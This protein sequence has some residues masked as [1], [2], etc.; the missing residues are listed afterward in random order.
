MN[1]IKF[2][3]K[4]PQYSDLSDKQLADALHEKFYKD[5]PIKQFY[6]DVGLS[7][8]QASAKNSNLKPNQN[9]D[10]T[11]ISTELA[12]NSITQ[13]IEP[14]QSDIL[15]YSLL[16]VVGFLFWLSKTSSN[17]KSDLKKQ[18]ILEAEYSRAKEF[19]KQTRLEAEGIKVDAVKLKTLQTELNHARSEIE[20]QARAEAER[21]KTTTAKQKTLEIE[22]NQIRTELEKRAR[23]EAERIKS[24]TARQVA[25]EAELNKSKTFEKHAKSEAELIKIE[26][27][28]LATLELDIKQA[29]E[30]LERRVRLEAERTKADALRQNA[31]EAE[32]NKSRSLEKQARMEA[33]RIKA[34]HDKSKSIQDG[35]ENDLNK[36][37][38]E[39]LFDVGEVVKVIGGAF[40]NFNGVVEEVNYE[41]NKLKISVLIIGR[42][43]SV[44]LSFEQVLKNHY[45]LGEVGPYGGIVFYV[46]DTGTIGAEVKRK[47]EAGRLNWHKSL[48]ATSES[49]KDWRLPTK[50][51]L[52]IL[53]V[54]K[55]L[56]GGFTNT[57]YWCSTEYN[58][59]DAWIQCF[60]TGYPYF[61]NKNVKKNNVRA[62]RSFDFSIIEAKKYEY[63]E[64]E[65]IKGNQV[66]QVSTS[67][68]VGTEYTNDGVV[69]I[70]DEN[71]DKFEDMF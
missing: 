21:I 46:N 51:E 36:T 60:N 63:P 4:Y 16:V 35:V 8:S 31:L 55:D 17:R 18:M 41:E 56:I 37:S 3:E 34:D 2:R 54:K 14:P 11:N 59:D 7:K 26:A 30:E 62:V 10:L 38:F 40:T 12:V 67:S 52:A 57:D 61:D 69:I 49:G 48:I 39:V 66:K 50:A 53:Y 9:T 24:D 13:P 43:T 70:K 6:R 68:I 19:E 29:R 1:I 15:F 20:K 32:L 44:E 64:I 28:K 42:T 23:L 47:D 65:E 45:K 33:E 71:V 58:N 25:L 5:I 22:L 27:A